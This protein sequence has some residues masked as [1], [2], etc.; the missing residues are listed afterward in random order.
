LRPQL[1][2]APDHGGDEVRRNAE[3]VELHDFRSAQVIR[4]QGILNVSHDHR[5]PNSALEHFDNFTDVP[6]ETERRGP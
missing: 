2:A 4:N 6:G 3:F 1:P 5:R